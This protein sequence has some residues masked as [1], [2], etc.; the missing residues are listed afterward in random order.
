MEAN[1]MAMTAA[2]RQRRRR[3]RELHVSQLHRTGAAAHAF[4]DALER[5]AAI[6]ARL[7]QE[8]G[9]DK[10][11]A[12]WLKKNAWDDLDTEDRRALVALGKF[13]AG[14]KMPELVDAFL[15][16]TSI[17]KWV[18]EHSKQASKV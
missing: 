13:R 5:L 7:E 8:Q 1:S 17:W 14:E 6:Y 4:V 16:P 9:G 10:P 12:A 2:E 18:R 15:S 3:N 11:F